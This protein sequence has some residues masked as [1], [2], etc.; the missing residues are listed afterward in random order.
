MPVST[1][2]NE[3]GS[4]AAIHFSHPKGNILTRDIIAG[5]RAACED[6]SRARAEADH[7]GADARILLGASVPS[8]RGGI[9]HA[10][11]YA[12]VVR[13]CARA[14]PDR[15]V[16]PAASW[17]RVRARARVDFIAAANDSTFALPRLRSASASVRSCAADQGG[18]ARA[19]G[20][21][22]GATQCAD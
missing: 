5:L 17:R 14:A 4:R 18:Y 16:V 9:E 15:R 11:R 20:R 3:E 13:D 6:L 8:T 12:R 2:F 1:A 10:L 7:A 19:L 21:P 22:P